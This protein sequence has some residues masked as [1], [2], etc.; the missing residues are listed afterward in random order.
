VKINT[1]R[2]FLYLAENLNFSATAKRFFI[3]QSAL[4]KHILELEKE[5]DA[6]LFLRDK[7]SVRLTSVGKLFIDEAQT[8]LEAHDNALSAVRGAKR[9]VESNLRIG[10][11]FGAARKFFPHACKLF[12][13]ETPD[14]KLSICSL[15]PDPIVDSLKKNIID[16]G[17]SLIVP[18]QSSSLFEYHKIYTDRFVLVVPSDHSLASRRSVE[19]SDIKGEVLIPANFPVHK[20]AHDF[21]L[22]RLS[23]AGIAFALAEETNDRESYPI[24]F[25]DQSCMSLSCNHLD[26]YY[27][28]FLRFIPIE[29]V[30]LNY[31]I[32]ALWKKSK[33][34]GSILGFVSCIDQA[35]A[36]LRDFE[37]ENERSADVWS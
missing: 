12:A 19:V 34:N 1:L 37:M 18:N 31:D 33:S 28:S 14:T 11:L 30:D 17:I 10:Y 6:K 24:I 32:S 21:L 3:N 8:V 15:E 9:Q 4:S 23:D 13:K 20:E 16:L 5:L 26:G 7:H 22:S 35:L 2:E 29:G 27:G 36:L 25:Q